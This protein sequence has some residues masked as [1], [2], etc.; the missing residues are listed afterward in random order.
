MV[1]DFYSVK[2]KRMCM[3]CYVMPCHAFHSGSIHSTVGGYIMRLM[4]VCMYSHVMQPHETPGIAVDFIVQV[5]A[6]CRLTL[7]YTTPFIA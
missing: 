4:I 2:N 6:I 7:Y 3:L 5:I 1:F